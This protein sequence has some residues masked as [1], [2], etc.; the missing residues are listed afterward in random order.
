MCQSSNIKYIT[1]KQTIVD[2][3]TGNSRV[4]INGNSRV[5]ITGNSRVTITGNSRVTIG[6]RFNV[7]LLSVYK[8]KV[9]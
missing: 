8:E 9:G 3:G 7:L 1:P 4:T 5:T 2:R 6:S